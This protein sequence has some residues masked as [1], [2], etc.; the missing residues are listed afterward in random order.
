MDWHINRET[1]L[2]ALTK[3]SGISEKKTTMQILG[4]VLVEASEDHAIT[5]SATDLDISLRTQVEGEVDTPGR[6]TVSARKFLELVKEL[7]HET[8]HCRLGEDQRLTVS[9]GHT[10]YRLATMRPEDFPHFTV[11]DPD[12]TFS[13]DTKVLAAAL[14]RT[15]YTV[16]LDEDPL[17]IP[18]LYWQLIDSNTLRFVGS[19]GHRL[20]YD[21]ISF[22]AE[23]LLSGQPGITVP[24][25]GIQEMLKILEKADEA[26]LGLHESRVFLRTGDTYLSIQLLEDEFP[27]YDMI[28]PEDRSGFFEADREIFHAALKRMAV[29]ADQT[30]IFVRFI[31]HPNLLVLEAGNP[32]LITAQDEIP[33]NSSGEEFTVAF[34]VRYV[35]DAVQSLRSSSIRFEWLDSLKGCLF[36]EPDNPDC[37]ALV[38]PMMV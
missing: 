37:L 17:S 12:K 23:E 27:Q 34:N 26:T 35:L 28:I 32:E 11:V 20:A 18:G 31:V 15:L 33:V 4:N 2:S 29:V 1:L 14:S 24:R 36:L 38:M 22:P 8:I 3:A 7:S 9:G 25:K 5:F 10:R 19:D 16:P 21:Q 30:W 6:T 13:V